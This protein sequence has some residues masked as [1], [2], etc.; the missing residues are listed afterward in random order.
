MVKEVS[1]DPVFDAQQAFRIL[2]NAFSH[3]GTL[4]AFEKYALNKPEALMAADAIV[5]LSLFDNNISF[6]ASSTYSENI[7][8]YI[9]LNT[10]AKIVSLQ[11][12]DYVFLKGKESIAQFIF[13]CKK[14]ELS[15]PEK[16][17]TL[18]IN[19]D[20]LSSNSL[21]GAACH[22]KLTGPGIQKEQVLCVKG[23]AIETVEALQTVN[24]E[25]PLGVDI[26]LTDAFDLIC[27]IPRSIALQIIQNN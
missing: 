20:Q 22:L 2:L 12:A 14:G 19:V 21:D 16:N 9:H 5:A 10:S 18:L 11:D 23:L 17:A 13:D 4:Y 25:F 1:F 6:H 24:A 15:Y 3:P 7:E 27:A 8:A 26:I